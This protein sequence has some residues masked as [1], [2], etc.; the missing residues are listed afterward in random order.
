MRA[1]TPEPPR[2]H[3]RLLRGSKS[4]WMRVADLPFSRG[5]V[6]RLILE[7]LLFSV[8]LRLPGSKRPVR[9][10]DGES[11]DQYLLK[12]GRDQAARKKALAQAAPQEAAL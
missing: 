3:P 10:I 5:H 12:L 11:L 2:P 6:Y 4:R 9:L 7:G 1:K 8:E